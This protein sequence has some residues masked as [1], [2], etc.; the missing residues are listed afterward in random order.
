MKRERKNKFKSYSIGGKI[1]NLYNY[2]YEKPNSVETFYDTIFTD[3]D[4]KGLDLTLLLEN[5]IDNSVNERILEKF[6][7]PIKKQFERENPGTLIVFNYPVSFNTH[8]SHGGKNAHMMIQ[9]ANYNKERVVG[10]KE[11]DKWSDENMGLINKAI[12]MVNNKLS[13]LK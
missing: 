12:E 7:K 13:L 5:G 3:I 8:K 1:Y 6:F 4:Y 10:S 2:P 11:I 9:L